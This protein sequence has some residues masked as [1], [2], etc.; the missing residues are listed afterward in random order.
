MSY[1][2]SQNQ[3]DALQLVYNDALTYGT[4]SSV[5]ATISALIGEN[6]SPKQGVDASVFSWIN[7]ALQV[8]ANDGPF[9]ENA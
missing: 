7:G 1:Q 4:W 6:G 3:I 5:Y 8:N 2:F 9:A